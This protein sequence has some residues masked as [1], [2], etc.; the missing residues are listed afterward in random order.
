[1]GIEGIQKTIGTHRPAF[2]K[3]IGALMLVALIVTLMPSFL[4]SGFVYP[5]FTMPDSFQA[6]SASLPTPY[7]LDIS[8][9]IVLRGAGL[10]ELWGNVAVLAG[11]TVAVFALAAWRFKKRLA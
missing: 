1:M 4:F 5:I 6:Y 10:K 9:G 2:V 11:Y 3:G 8:R 7:F